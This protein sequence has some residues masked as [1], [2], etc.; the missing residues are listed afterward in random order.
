M[1]FLNLIVFPVII[2]SESSLD[3]YITEFSSS[4]FS[5]NSSVISDVSENLLIESEKL[6]IA[7]D[8]SSDVSESSLEI[9][10]SFKYLRLIPFFVVLDFL[11][12]SKM[13]SSLFI[14]PKTL[15][16][17]AIAFVCTKLAFVAD[18]VVLKMYSV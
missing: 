1:L 13:F 5:E 2:S 10:F 6:L 7:V 18:F 4:S 8:S 12:I 15:S 11:L 17:F 16:N 9:S 3:K 14:W